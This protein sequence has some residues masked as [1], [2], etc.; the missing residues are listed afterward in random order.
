MD[1]KSTIADLEFLRSQ[2][3]DIDIMGHVRR[4]GF[5]LGICGGYQML[6]KEIIDDEGF[7]GKA[8]RSKGLSLL[9][10]KTI[11]EKN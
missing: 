7:D 5:V 1:P 6:G 4:G 3:W 2:N 10:I 8:S 11:M 9:N